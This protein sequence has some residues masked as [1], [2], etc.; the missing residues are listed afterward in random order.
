MHLGYKVGLTVGLIGIVSLALSIL[1]S[2][3]D[4]PI[5]V[6]SPFVVLAI[7]GIIIGLVVLAVCRITES[8]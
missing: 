8:N 2:W 1:L 7:F 5:G 3:V 6:T 4:A